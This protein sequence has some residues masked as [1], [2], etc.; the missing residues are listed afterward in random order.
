MIY[1][2]GLDQPI[3]TTLEEST[4]EAPLVDTWKIRILGQGKSLGVEEDLLTM[5]RSTSQI[6]TNLEKVDKDSVGSNITREDMAKLWST[7]D[8]LGRDKRA[9]LVWHHIPNHCSFKYLLRIYKRGIIPKNFIKII[10]PP[11]CYPLVWKFPQ[12]A[13]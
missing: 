8:L 1:Q 10:T 6:L 11:L 12:E 2:K 13:M 9:V 7:K 3:Y 4:K 5:T